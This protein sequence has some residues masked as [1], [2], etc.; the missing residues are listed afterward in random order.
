MTGAIIAVSY[1]RLRCTT[2]MTADTPNSLSKQRSFNVANRVVIY[3]Y[4]TAR[5]R[6]KQQGLQ[7]ATDK[8]TPEAEVQK[9]HGMC[10][11]VVKIED[12]SQ[13]AAQFRA[14]YSLPSLSSLARTQRHSDR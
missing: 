10:R 8:A 9:L 4:I 1:D 11:K 14:R 7:R 2:G 13:S 3:L 6:R 5:Q 12:V